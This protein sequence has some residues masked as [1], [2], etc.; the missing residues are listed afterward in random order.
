MSELNQ[1]VPNGPSQKAYYR[2]SNSLK[3]LSALNR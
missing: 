3:F 1:N 2:M